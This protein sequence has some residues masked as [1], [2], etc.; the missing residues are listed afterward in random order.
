ML[1]PL[2][3]LAIYLCC[4]GA[5]GSRRNVRRKALASRGA[6]PPRLDRGDSSG[7][8]GGQVEP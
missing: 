4:A 8:S 7:S 1:T 3:L 5:G 6:R 2:L